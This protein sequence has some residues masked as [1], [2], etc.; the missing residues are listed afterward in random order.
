MAPNTQYGQVLA[1][2]FKDELNKRN[3]EIVA[4]EYFEEG[5]NDFSTQ[6]KNMR[7]KL[8]Y[9]HLEKIA[10]D[11]GLDF[12]GVTKA[13]SIK[14]ED[15][16][17]AVDGLFIPA[18]AADVVMLAPQVYFHRI[19]TQMLGSNGWH[20]PEV[21][22][23]GKRYVYNTMISTGFEVNPEQKEWQEFRKRFKAKYNYEPDRIVALGFDAAMITL[24]SL[25]AAGDDP[26]R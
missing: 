14:Y 15:S 4:E 17:L 25:K 10:M 2:S 22:K 19:R 23:E 21:L 26:K 9:R 16:T 1:K 8:L 24:K 7:S 5:G 13:D 3:A 18:D 11:K 12:N 6:F 20:N